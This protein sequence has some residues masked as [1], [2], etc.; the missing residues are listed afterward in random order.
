MGT[1]NGDRPFVSRESGILKFGINAKYSG[2]KLGE[3]EEG[4]T[5]IYAK[6]G[7]HQSMRDT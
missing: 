5:I 3:A 2:A 4:E 7:Q 1:L 6:I